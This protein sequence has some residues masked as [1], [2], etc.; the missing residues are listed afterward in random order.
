[1]KGKNQ[2]WFTMY[3]VRRMTRQLTGQV[4]RLTFRFLLVMAVLLGAC[5]AAAQIAGQGI[6]P[7]KQ[8]TIKHIEPDAAKEEIRVTFSQPIPLEVLRYKLKMV[9]PVKI[10]WQNSSVTEEGVLTL[11]G[12]FKYGANYVINLPDTFTYNRR[13]YVKRLNTFFL[14]DM[15]PKAAF[16]DHKSVI[17]RDSRQLLQ[18]QVRNLDRLVLESMKV[19]PILL[20]MA[21]ASEQSGDWQN[22]LAQL[23]A[24]LD[25]LTPLVKAPFKGL[26]PIFLSPP[27]QDKQL[28]AT[29]VQKNKPQAF[30][31]PLTFRP[32]KETGATLLI[33]LLDE[34][35]QGKPAGASQLFRLTDLGL[36]Y[37][38]GDQGLLL[39]VT[40]LQN[41]APVAGA[42]ILAFTQDLEVF[43]LGQTSPDGIL[44]FS[45]RELE[46]V[47]LKQTGQFSV[48]K[49]PLDH[50]QITFLMAGTAEDVSHIAVQPQGNLTPE[51]IWQVNKGQEIKNRRGFIFTDRGVYRPGEKVSFKGTIRQYQDGAI[52][53]PGPGTYH[54]VITSPKG[55]EVYSQN[56]TLSDFGSAWGE[57]VIQPHL[58]RGTYTLALKLETGTA[59]ATEDTPLSEEGESAA[60]DT[61]SQKPTPE[62]TCTFQV[63]DFKPPRHFVEIAFQRFSRPEQ[64][65]VNRPGQREFVRINISGSYYAGGPVKHGQV[66]WKVTTAKTS[67][68]VPGFDDFTFG[69]RESDKS[70]LLEN[71]QAIL[72]ENGQAVVEFPLESKVL[73]GLQGLT[74]TAT[75]VDFDGRSVA[76][77]KDFQV[78][79]EIL[80]GI[81]THVGEIRAGDE[82]MVKAIVTHKGKKINQGQL[83]AEVLQQSSTY[84]AKRNE[85]GDVY[86]DYQD[87]WRKLYTNE[88]PLK[89]GEASFRFDF[90]SGGEYL[91]SFTYLDDKGRSFASSTNYKVTGDFYWDDYENRE[92]PY[93]ALAV[94][95]DRPAYEPGQKAKI[96]VSPRRPVARYLVT[97]EQNGVLEHRVLAAPAGLQLLEIPIKAEYTPN[98]Y[99]S[100]LGLTS[101]GDFPA[102]ANRYDSEAPDF[103]WGTINLPVRQQAE[104]LEV[105]ISPT[106]KE[107]KAEPGAQ[108]ELDFSV[109]GKDGRGIEAE[110]AVVVVDERVLALTAFK[111]P[112]PES[113]VLFNRPLEVFTGELRTMLMQQTPFSLARNEPLTG[114]GGLEPGAEALMGKIRKRFDPCAYFNPALKTDGQGRAKVSFTMPD[115][116][117]T[118]RVYAVV[119]DRG[120]RFANAQRPFLV[121]KDFYL[122]PGLPAFFTQ[123][124]RF[125]FQVAAFNA[126]SG[127]GPM[128]LRTDTEGGLKLSETARIELP[129]K[130]SVKVAVTGSAEAPGPVVARFFGNFQSKQDAVEETLQI[131]SGQVLETTAIFGSLPVSTDIKLTL[132]PYVT[133]AEAGKSAEV[134]AVLTLAGSP[135]LR[136]TDAI[137][138]LLKYPYG[139]VE[140]TS[141]GVL[142]LAALRGVIADGLVP[143]ITFAETDTFLAKG[144]S[145]ILGMQIDSGGF[146]YWPG[147]QKAHPW[148]T[149][150]ATMALSLAKQKGLEVPAGALEKANSYLK[151]QVLNPKSPDLLRAYGAYILSFTGALDRDAFQAILRQYAKLSRE[152]KILLLL[153][154]KQANLMS[155]KDLPEALKPLLKGAP[156]TTAE[157]EDDFQARY[158]G[159]ALAL[160]AAKTILS[161]D[162]LTEQAALTLL[163]GLDH[164]GVWT[165]TSD[166]GW[167]LLALGEYFRG[168]KFGTAPMEIAVQ[169]PGGQRQ[170]LSL[171]PKG[172]R[173]L[174]LD[175]QILLKTPMVRVETS[176]K[177]TVLYKVELTAPRTDIAATGATNGL[178]V[179]KQI[180]NTDGTA[181]IK[182]GD[183]VKVTV[184]AQIQSKDQR[185]LVLDDPLPA[186]LVAV[187]TAF[188]TEEQKP[189]DDE[190]NQEIDTLEYI[191]PEGMFRLRPDFFEIRSDRVLAFKDYAYSGNYLFEY[192]ARAVCEGEFVQPATKAA[193]MYNPQVYG[194][195]TKGTMAVKGRQP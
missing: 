123:G 152:A 42:Q 99:V 188:A 191:T 179:W 78:D 21:V 190:E 91:V 160:L 17:E 137:R 53:P 63:Q 48:V 27:R 151:E 177:G 18:V 169:Q 157:T 178:K 135:F 24:G 167:S 193:A 79:P 122:E 131:N 140:Q 30:S 171:D 20:P 143:G 120:S 44:S 40:S 81:G 124:D 34:T 19:P 156:E 158:R 128:S 145:R 90:S 62:S 23:K 71:G 116:M 161:N 110:M 138:Y 111:T 87:I 49:R 130:N 61:G 32:D 166:T 31:L 47:S 3:V 165:S 72:D 136:M 121:T 68:Q 114:G 195:S 126:T 95:A 11:R 189:D 94:S 129:A 58:P 89:N 45:R 93:R 100:V 14:P 153:A 173:T 159:P 144:I 134:K 102:Y 162:P 65:Y 106:V 74:V 86:W 22:L 108:V 115:T 38:V 69:C 117:T 96:M 80:V 192:F 8:F 97:L 104:R 15:T 98:V 175:P 182:V 88:I 56:V 57:L 4:G 185:Y 184:F 119:L 174:S 59:P 113:L 176:A 9:P 84:V 112:D 66:R 75:V 154:G 43:S 76:N 92:K 146:A 54:F 26:N 148:G 35:R 125:R 33:R 142:G 132:P 101:R 141:S 67:Y 170:Q 60:P 41:G 50:R 12:T 163:G 10:N 37:K 107:L 73:S 186:G 82:Q 118:Y 181:E 16:V 164:K 103:F 55:E 105:K 133:T 2:G 13:T 28:F 109:Q 52:V 155:A 168:H 70:E 51:G 83:R 183:L 150:Y 25:E 64:R 180:K 85:Q 6:N 39:W 46:G 77:T 127:S 5:P 147:S 36:T 172:F 7:E 1:V 194:F 139:C 187:N 29:Q 149:V